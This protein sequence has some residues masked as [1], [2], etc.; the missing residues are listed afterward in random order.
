MGVEIE[1]NT[2]SE[3]E[4][5]LV[6]EQMSKDPELADYIHALE[7]SYIK[8]YEHLDASPV[9]QITLAPSKAKHITTFRRFK[10]PIVR[11]T[12]AAVVLLL[13]AVISLPVI[14]EFVTPDPYAIIEESLNIELPFV[15]GESESSLETGKALF[16]NG[17]YSEAITLFSEKIQE[18]HDNESEMAN[19]AFYLG[20]TYLH[21]AQKSTAG[22]FTGYD[23]AYIDSSYRYLELAR[24]QII[25]RV[26]LRRDIFWYLAV[27]ETIRYT[28]K[29][30]DEHYARA[31]EYLNFLV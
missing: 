21:H 28:I 31:E 8:F 29:H 9:G 23:S 19:C 20:L 2:L 12:S 7:K 11:Y 3:E 5:T 27:V 24:S 10:A 18:I 22:L 14:S 17:R 13:I 30:K 6:E 26:S 1:D 15:R 25:D 16:N 4:K